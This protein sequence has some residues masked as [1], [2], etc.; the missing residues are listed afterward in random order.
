[1]LA[2]FTRLSSADGY[3]SERI[4]AASFAML[5]IR[6]SK[7]ARADSKHPIVGGC[8]PLF[9]TAEKVTHVIHSAWI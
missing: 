9:G 4:D 7:H 3:S 8:S 6:Q 2:N 5:S 1:M